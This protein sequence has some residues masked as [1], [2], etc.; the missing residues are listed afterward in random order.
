MPRTPRTH[1][2]RTKIVGM[3]CMPTKAI[4]TVVDAFR[5]QQARWRTTASAYADASWL[6]HQLAR[7]SSY[8]DRY[9]AKACAALFLASYAPRL[10]S[11]VANRWIGQKR[12][13]DV[14]PDRVMVR[15]ARCLRLDHGWPKFDRQLDIALE[16]CDCAESAELALQRLRTG[17]EAHFEPLISALCD[18]TGISRQALWRLIGDAVAFAFLDAGRKAGREEEAKANALI[19][20]KHAGSSLDNRQLHYFQLTI[21]DPIRTGKFVTRTFRQ[22]GGCCR[23]YTA[24]PGKL[25]STCVLKDPAERDQGLE[26]GLLRRLTLLSLPERLYRNAKARLSRYR[27]PGSGSSGGGLRGPSA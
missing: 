19:L 5:P 24:F 11:A 8:S 26:A 9:D 3:L 21:A 7:Q 12:L 1:R 13:P 6:E 25:C 2:A 10:A 17:I 4:V 22:R 14:A 18:Q 15:E 20:L 23:Y 16:G 27:N